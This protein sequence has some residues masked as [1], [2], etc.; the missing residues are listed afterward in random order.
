MTPARF[1]ALLG[2]VIP[3]PA[4]MNRRTFLAAST[5]ALAA[6]SLPACSRK[7]GSSAR[8]LSVYT[9]ADYLKPSLKERFEEE[10]GCKVTLTTFDS[11]EAMYAKLKAGASGFDVIVPSSYMVKG[12]NREGM[13]RTLDQAKLPN[14][15]H[16]DPAYLK[17]ALDPMMEYS[18]PYMIGITCLGWRA[19]KL[20]NAEASYTLLDRPDLKGRITLLDDMREVL[21]AALK[22]L[23]LPLNSADSAHLAKA[24]DVAVRWKRNIAK[25]DSEQYKSGISSGEFQLVQGYAG[26]LLQVSHEQPE[27]A[28]GIPREGSSMSCDDLCIPKDAVEIDLAHAFINFVTDPK[29]AAENMQ[30]IGFRAPNKDAYVL[31]DEDFSGSAA[32]FPPDELLAKCETID[33][34]GPALS[35]WSKTWD[36]VKAA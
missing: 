21:G 9:W 6:A 12:M 30:E 14:L 20:Q 2:G 32:L 24:R 27:V 22:S 33:D 11:N 35:L 25:F 8:T 10:Q 29:V 16:I 18:V 19:D 26:D 4:P 28:V 3:P 17:S 7:S 34:L 13:L 5:G 1:A 31:L 36:E 23:G 15:L